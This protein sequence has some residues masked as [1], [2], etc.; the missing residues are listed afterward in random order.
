MTPLFV[1]FDPR[2]ELVYSSPL[3]EVIFNCLFLSVYVISDCQTGVVAIES[4]LELVMVINVDY[5][6][7][8]YIETNYVPGCFFFPWNFFPCISM[9][10][11]RS[12]T[13]Y[14]QCSDTGPENV[15]ME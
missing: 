2:V 9:E 12:I 5:A 3:Y 11:R 6:I 10:E 13:G 8:F 14:C 7:E 1:N 15:N 4:R